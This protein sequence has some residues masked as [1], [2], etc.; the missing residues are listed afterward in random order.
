MPY[1]SVDAAV[2]ESILY[3]WCRTV[4]AYLWLLGGQDRTFSYADLLGNSIGRLDAYSQKHQSESNSTF[5]YVTINHF[6]LFYS[7]Y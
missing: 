6:I 1:E 3:V 5:G 7:V 2:Y 4:D